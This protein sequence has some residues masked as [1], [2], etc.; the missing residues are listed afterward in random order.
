MNTELTKACQCFIDNYRIISGIFKQGYSLIY[1]VCSDIFCTKGKKA[2]EKLLNDCA[3]MILDRS[4]IFGEFHGIMY[5]PVASIIA[6]SDD[7]EKFVSRMEKVHGILRKYFQPSNYLVLTAALMA[8]NS[9]DKDMDKNI[10]R[11]KRIYD[12]MAKKHPFLTSNEDIVFATYLALS[13]RS[14]DELI[15]DM[16]ESF[17]ILDKFAVNDYIQTVTHILS[18]SPDKPKKKCKNFKDLYFRLC[19]DD[20][21]F[22]RSFGLS[23]LAALSTIGHDNKKLAAEINEIADF[24]K[25]DKEYGAKLSSPVEDP[26]L[27]A[28]IILLAV[29]APG[30]SSDAVAITSIFYMFALHELSSYSM[31]LKRRCA[32]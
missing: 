11:A 24:L 3:R 28:A 26:L 22:K 4:Q 10:D 30:M 16:E 7:A 20:M 2:D 31:D 19:T 29:Y 17:T 14:D 1:P 13:P 12:L 9:D 21:K 8:E 5:A 23:V 15:D 32:V 18:L 25:K 27:H 6:A